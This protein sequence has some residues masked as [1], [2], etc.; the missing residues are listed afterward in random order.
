M[1]IDIDMIVG[2]QPWISPYYTLGNDSDINSYNLSVNKFN[3]QGEFLFSDWKCVTHSDF[4]I[5][6]IVTALVC[7]FT[8][9]LSFVKHEVKQI[10][11]EKRESK[12]YK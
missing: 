6:L 9:F 10:N 12:A 11:K 1:P 5:I 2:M 7:V 3:L 4:T 8:E